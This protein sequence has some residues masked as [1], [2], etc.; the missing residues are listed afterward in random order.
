LSSNEATL[1]HADVIVDVDSNED[2]E[3]VEDVAERVYEFI[4]FVVEEYD[5]VDEVGDGGPATL[6]V[7]NGIQFV[8]PKPLTL[9]VS[10]F[11]LPLPVFTFIAP[12]APIIMFPRNDIGVG[13]YCCGCCGAS[14]PA[15]RTGLAGTTGKRNAWCTRSSWM[16]D[17]SSDLSGRLGGGT[18]NVG[19]DDDDDECAKDAASTCAWASESVHV[20]RDL[21][22]DDV[23][24]DDDGGGCVGY[25]ENSVDANGA[26]AET[27]DI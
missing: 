20:G 12:M 4:E 19:R 1:E 2:T 26:C 6:V 9:L 7:G 5:V 8:P 17:C 23:G 13:I 25:D 24:N 14:S 22:Y 15:P 3:V 10:P 21:W 11:F 18:D 27:T 16:G